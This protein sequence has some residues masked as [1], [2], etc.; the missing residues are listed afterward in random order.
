MRFRQREPDAYRN[1]ARI[2]LVSSFIASLF[3]GWIAP[4]DI[5]DVCG[6]NLRDI[7]GGSYNRK[8]MELAAGEFG[9]ADLEKKMGPVP[10]DGGEHYGPVSN[11]FVEKWG[12]NPSA[13]VISC[14]G[15]NPS[16]IMAL[17]LRPMD[18]MV[19]LGTS[20]TFLM[21][22]PKYKP[23]P[24]YHFF[25][26]P[27]TAGLYMF[28]L[29]YKNGGLAREHVRD[30]LNEK[31]G[32]SYDKTNVWS[33]FDETA[34]TTAPLCQKDESDSMKMGLFFP[35]HEIVPNLPPGEW[36]Y[37]YNPQ[38][39]AIEETTKGWNC[40]HDD[41]RAI[42][43]SQMLSLRLRSQALMTRTK[44][45]VPAQPRRI[46]LVG[47]GSQNAAIAK[48]VGEVLGG[49]EGVFKLDVGE[50]ACALGS[51]YKAVWAME[52]AD[53]EAFEDFV[54]S[55]WKESKF[56]KKIAEG[57]QKGVFEKYGEALKGFDLMEKQA[58]AQQAS[59]QNGHANGFT[60]GHTIVSTPLAVQM[61]N[62]TGYANENASYFDRKVLSD[63]RRPQRQWRFG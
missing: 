11:Y 18:A 14:T 20:T 27:T 42:V 23:D 53:D 55:R 3:L 5:S 32:G 22:T 59:K 46:Y 13:T 61:A 25:N 56:V 35:R 16:T 38:K 29:C 34:T 24:A 1:T 47:G 37:A 8:L 39:D 57:Y 7:H 4:L 26:S 48:I 54:G 28:M 33:N 58:L 41:A 49:T 19:S 9:A 50:N 31:I 15:D 43:E 44:G 2:S 17:P 62:I 36:H 52:R 6:M 12:F 21:S 30:A 51:A 10:E 60:N 45:G 40:P 63:G